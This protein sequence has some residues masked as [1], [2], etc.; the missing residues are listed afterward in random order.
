MNSFMYSFKNLSSEFVE[1]ANFVQNKRPNQF[2]LK[3]FNQQSY[4]DFK[5][6]EQQQPSQ[7]QFQDQ[8]PQLS[9]SQYFLNP[10]LSLELKSKLPSLDRYIKKKKIHKK[11]KQQS[12]AIRDYKKNICR[13]ILRHSIKGIV[14]SSS[15]E[16]LLEEFRNNNQKLI[17]FQKFYQQ[18]LEIISGFRVLKDHLIIQGDEPKEE[19]ERKSVFQKYLIWFLSSQATKCILQSEAN[20]IA[21]YIHYKNDVLLYYVQ[22]PSQ[23]YSNKPLWRKKE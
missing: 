22:Q 12:A 3:I 9:I 14:N 18:N 2:C 23:W 11:A 13:N 21:E 19:Q 1:S 8:Y 15:Q 10:Q 4:E 7:Q 5:L 20:N 16:F 6:E 17:E